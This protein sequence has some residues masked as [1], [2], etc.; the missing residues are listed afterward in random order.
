M[1]VLHHLVPLAASQL[2]VV[3]A[4]L[5]VASHQLLHERRV[6][7]GGSVVNLNHSCTRHHGVV[8]QLVVGILSISRNLRPQRLSTG[9]KG[10]PKAVHS[11]HFFAVEDARHLH[12]GLAQQVVFRVLRDEGGG[13]L[14]YFSRTTAEHGSRELLQ[15]RLLVAS[16]DGF[17]I[18]GIVHDEVDGHLLGLQVAHVD[19]PD[20]VDARLIGEVE[21]LAQFGNGGGVHPSV[22]P[23]ATVH[24]DMVVEAKSS[25]AFALEV[26]SDATDV[27]PV[28]VAKQ[29]GHVVGHREASIVVTLHFG[30]DGPQLRHSI[31]TPIHLLDDGTLT[32]HHLG[33]GLHVV[34]VIALSHRHIAVASHTDGDKIVVVLVALHALEEKL[35]HSLLVRGIIPRSHLLLPLQVFAMRPHH[36]LMMRSAHHNAVLIGQTWAFG[37]ILIEGRCPHGWPQVVGL[38]AQE[39]LKHVGI[40]LGVHASEVFRCPSAK[41]GPFVVDEDATILHFGRWLHKASIRPIH[42]VLMLHRHICPPVPGRHTYSLAYLVD[43]V[44]GASLVASSHHQTT[45]HHIDNERLPLPL[46]LVYIE[47]PLLHKPVN[48]AALTNGSDING[49]SAI[50]NFQLSIFN[51]HSTRC[52]R[53]PPHIVAQVAGSAN[54]S[55]P[56][57]LIHHDGSRL[58]VFG[59]AELLTLC[60]H[61]HRHHNTGDAYCP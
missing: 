46:H 36:R 22:V 15:P 25:L 51:F 3:V 18:P 33:Q 6:S 53:H 45:V 31:L 28:V 13:F 2:V 54:H 59:N 49:A 16:L 38:Q 11:V 37:V 47:F 27:A 56:I 17:G 58:A 60:C 42:L 8:H 12:F 61:V 48:Q 30:E 4:E 34:L 14:D 5:A 39:Q 10:E 40:H 44:D 43:A 19:D 24:V 32:L 29:Q 20:A 9:S 1:I 52:A 50:F 26:A 7:T 21:L 35:I 23:R 57:L 55:Y 41:R